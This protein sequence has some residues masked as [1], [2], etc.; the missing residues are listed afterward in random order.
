M[1]HEVR[2]APSLLSADF[3]KLG[4]DIDAISTADYIHFDVMDGHFVPN[5]SFGLPI[6]K[7]SL[8]HI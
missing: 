4:E 6:L 8:I 1:T 7:L 5:L 2:I 3:M